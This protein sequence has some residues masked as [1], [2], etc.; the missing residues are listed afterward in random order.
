MIKNAEKTAGM[1]CFIFDNAGR[2]L[3]GIYLTHS[4]FTDGKDK[5]LNFFTK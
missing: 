3:S 2:T 4:V 1:E 5:V